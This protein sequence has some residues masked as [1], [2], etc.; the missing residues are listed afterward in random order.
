MKNHPYVSVTLFVQQSH[1]SFQQSGVL[2][3]QATFDQDVV[4]CGFDVRP[5]LHYE[6]NNIPTVYNIQ[7]YTS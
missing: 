3:P 5:M 1:N 6:M 4:F 2:S 7:A